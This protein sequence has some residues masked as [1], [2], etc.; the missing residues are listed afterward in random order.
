MNSV[1]VILIILVIAVIAFI[2]YNS[3]KATGQRSAA[4]LADA[5][6]DARRVIERLGGQVLNL[7]G[8]DNASRAGAGR[9]FRALHGRGLADRAGHHRPPGPARQGERH[10]GP[11]LRAGCAQRD[12]DGPRS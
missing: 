1:L 2:V 9:R 12:G 10:R 3:S 4:A 7:T 11:V 5:K 6:A 8:S